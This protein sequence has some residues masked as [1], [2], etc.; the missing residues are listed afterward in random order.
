VTDINVFELSQ[1]GSFADPLTEVLRNG[2]RALLT[3]AVEAEVAALLSCHADK[4]MDDGRQRLVRHGHLPER[5][6][7]TGIGPVTVRCPRV[8]DRV[9]EGAERIR[10]SSAILPPYARRSKSL[11]V[12]IP[13]LYLKGI[14]TGDFEE[15]LIA[16]LGKDAGG[17]S[18][19]TISRLKE[20]WAEEHAHWSKRDLSAKRYVYFWVD[21]IHVQARLEDAAQCLLVIIG[22]TPEG[23]KELVGLT[24]GVRESAQ[25]WRELLLDLKRRGLAMGPELAV[26]D[27]ALGFWQAVEEVWP[28][29]RGQRCWVHKT[30]NVLNKLPKSQQSKAKRALQEIWMAETKN[31]ALM[32][33]DAFVETWSIKYDRAVDCLIKDR[34]ALLAF[35]EFP[36]EHW[37]HLRTTNVIES[38]FATVRHRTVRSKGCLSNKTALAMIF[39]LA[40]AAEKS[41]RRLDGHN[42][43]PK[44]ILGVRFADGIEIKSQAQ[45]AAA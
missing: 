2:A 9:G 36:A 16:L 4:L 10:F 6:I 45:A 26:A 11:E 22:A 40:E 3:Q 14:S 32:A 39:K 42:Q 25:S 24:D 17:L 7:M 29:T 38:S 43:L 30:A 23:K 41:W 37:K 35:Y 20:A 31:D 18:A 21:G 12:L 27:G 34:D 19:S 44:V 33:F 28:L 1:P 5:E 15:A 13:V 8:R